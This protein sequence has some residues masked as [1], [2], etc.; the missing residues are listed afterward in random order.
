MKTS[1]PFR[2]SLLATALALAGAGAAAADKGPLD[3]MSQVFEDA[4][5]SGDVVAAANLYADDGMILPPNYAPVQGRG[6]IAAYFK[7]MTDNGFSLKLTPTDSWMDG[8]LAVRTGTYIVV[9]KAQKEIEHGKWLEVWKQGDDGRWLLVRDMWN[10]S[11]PV[12]PPPTPGVAGDK[13]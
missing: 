3:S 1:R 5:R 11:D 8:K 13:K 6:A 12:P 7:T 4:I 10:S 9:D 2:L